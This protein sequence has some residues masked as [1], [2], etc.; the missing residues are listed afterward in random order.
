MPASR[1]T[2]CWPRP[3]PTSISTTSAGPP[4]AK[5]LLALAAEA[6]DAARAVKGVTN[7]EGAEASWGRTAHDAGHQQRL[8]RRLPPQRLLALLRG[9]GRRRHRHGAR[10][11][12]VARDPLRRP[13]GGRQGR[14]Q[15]RPLRRRAAQPEEGRQR[16]ACRWSTTA[17]FRA[18]CS[19]ILPAPS[20]AAAWRAARRSSRTAWASGSSPRASASSTIR[21]ASAGSGSRPFDDE[22]LP[23]KRRAVI[24]DGVLTTW[25]LD[26]A[27]ARQLNLSRPATARQRLAVRIS[28]SR[29]A[30]SRPRS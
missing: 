26:L 9:A 24:D 6:E 8:R 22:G 30:S 11:R 5:T 14:P 27:S 3:G 29:R 7:S 2:S 21:T 28:I 25:F 19:A 13:D 16:R 12:M 20:T 15:R 18:A 10:L 23:T 4:S 1:R 17:A